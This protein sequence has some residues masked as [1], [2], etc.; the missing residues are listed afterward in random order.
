MCWGVILVFHTCVRGGDKTRVIRTGNQQSV[1]GMVVN[2]DGVPR[3][4]RRIK[5]QLRAAIHNLQAGRALRDGESLDTLSGYA[6]W[7][8]SA[9]PE[10]GQ[11]Y[12]AQIAELAQPVSA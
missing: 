12:L 6:A 1:T 7:I 11:R 8:A 4:P 3:V 2:G 5:R 9:E 10:L